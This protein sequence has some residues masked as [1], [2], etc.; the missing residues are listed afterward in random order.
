[1]RCVAQHDLPYLSTLDY[2]RLQAGSEA[3]LLSGT[4]LTFVYGL[5]FFRHAAAH[6]EELLQQAECFEDDFSRFTF[7]CL[8]NYRLTADPNY[9]SRCAIGHHFDRAGFNTYT[10]NR[11]FFEFSADEVFVDGGGFDGDS[12]ENFVT[13]TRGRFRHVY[14]FE[15][16]PELADKCEQRRRRLDDVHAPGISRRIS[17]IRKGLWSHTARLHFNPTL[18]AGDDAANAAP[19]PQSAHIIEAGITS[20]MY[21]PETEQQGGFDVDVVSIDEACDEPVSLIKLEIEGSELEALHGATRTIS[22][23]RPK[24]ALSAYHKAEDLLTLPRFVQRCDLGY[25]MSLRLH[26]ATVPDALVCYCS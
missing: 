21:S 1:M 13:A 18:F 2:F 19:V 17:V 6:F 23:N 3:A 15:P 12:M 11:S 22:A 14:T 26:N 8:L 24:M 20:H 5:S 16:F 7:F 9:L 4:G 25:K 10:F